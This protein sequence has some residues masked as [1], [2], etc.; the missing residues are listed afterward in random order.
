MKKPIE[1]LD[2]YELQLC[3]ST[4]PAD[5]QALLIRRM[6]KERGIDPDGAWYIERMS[7]RSTDPNLVIEEVD[8][9]YKKRS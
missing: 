7:M 2:E 5:H 1:E 6:M 3:E 8:Y 4:D 9:D